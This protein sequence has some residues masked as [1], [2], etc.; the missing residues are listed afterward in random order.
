[1]LDLEHLCNILMIIDIDIEVLNL[2]FMSL[3]CIDQLWLQNVTGTTPGSSRLNQDRSLA[4]LECILPVAV[5]FHLFDVAWL[6]ATC[7][8]WSVC[9]T[10]ICGTHVIRKGSHCWGSELEES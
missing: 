9:A 7:I 4:I 1:M 8:N 3:H 2:A 5:S 10:H 6:L